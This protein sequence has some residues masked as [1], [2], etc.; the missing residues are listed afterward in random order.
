MGMD[1]DQLPILDQYD[2]QPNHLALPSNDYPHDSFV[3]EQYHHNPME[4]YRHQQHLHQIHDPTTF[5]P[6]V[7]QTPQIQHQ[8]QYNESE[9]RYKTPI[10]SSNHYQPDHP[11]PVL[12]DVREGEPGEDK[13]EEIMEFG[14]STDEWKLLWSSRTASR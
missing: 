7:Y 8:P 10:P 1:T 4:P 2:H 9:R 14:A 12:E 5:S 13:E 3:D 6:Q 11:G